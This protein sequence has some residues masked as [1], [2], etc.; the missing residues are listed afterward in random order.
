M[1][2]NGC[3]FYFS[4]WANFCPFTSQTAWKIKILKKW[5]KCLEISPFYNSVPKIMIICYTVPEIWCMTG[6]IIFHFGLFLPFYPPNSP[7]NQNLKKMKRI[8]GDIIISHMCTKNYN[9]MMFGS[10][11][12]VCDRWMDRGTDRKS[13]I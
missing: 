4:F 1:A 10:W 8:P 6:V 12:M 7:K 13:D 9:P 11:D 2:H 3:N 5:K